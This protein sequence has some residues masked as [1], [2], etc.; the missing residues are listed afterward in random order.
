M[1]PTDFNK[2]APGQ[3]VK[4]LDGQWSFVP[5]ALPPKFDL[6]WE[7]VHLLSK[8][9]RE[10]GRLAGAGQ[11]LPNPHLL[12][13][14]FLRR[15]A[16]LSSRIEGTVSTADELLLFEIESPAEPPKPDVREVSNYVRAMEYGLKRLD[17]LPV[18]LR[19]VGELH[20]KLMQGVRGYAQRPGEFRNVQNYIGQQ[21]QPINTARFV[22]PPVEQMHQSLQELEKFWGNPSELPV[23][24]ELALIH[25]QFEAIHPFR[26]GNGRIGRL[27]ITLL[28]CERKLLPQPLLYLSAYLER[29][30][31]AYMDHLLAI[32]QRGAWVE[33]VNFFLRGV[34]EQSQDAVERLNRLL[35]LWRGYRQK[36]Q[37]AQSSALCLK[38]VDELFRIPAITVTGAAKLL[39]VTHRAAQLNVNKLVAGGILKEVTHRKRNRIYVATEIVQTIE[40]N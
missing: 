28:L 29:N 13:G 9:E 39:D 24:V 11:N 1:K 8:A 36:L 23:L 22:P 17:E 32:S 6:N 3:V 38:L 34:A 21:G 37:L 30:R 2:N 4:N 15:E 27:L 31:N 25:Y 33:W 35:E 12:I 19:L 7:T 16:I 26:D 20:E 5:A 40:K 10:L 18:C 14:S